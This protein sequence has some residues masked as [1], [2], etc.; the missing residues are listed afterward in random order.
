MECAGLDNNSDLDFLLKKGGECAWLKKGLVC[1]L[2]RGGGETDCDG[3]RCLMFLARAGGEVLLL[4][5]FPVGN[6]AER[7]ED[8]E[9][10]LLLSN[11]RCFF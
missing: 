8:G 6:G 7:G 1:F 11:T 3:R 4:W 10:C 5:L 2:L 9:L